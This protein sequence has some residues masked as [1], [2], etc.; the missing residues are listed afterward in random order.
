MKHNNN[1]RTIGK[2]IVTQHKETIDSLIRMQDEDR[3]SLFT[4]LGI[5]VAYLNKHDLSDVDIDK[6]NIIVKNILE[7]YEIHSTKILKEK[8]EECALNLRVSELARIAPL[9]GVH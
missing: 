9:G 3:M 2:D 1:I 5:A 6:Q 4:V 8:T 7:R